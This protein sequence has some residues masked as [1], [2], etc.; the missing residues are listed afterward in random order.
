MLDLR[1]E[2]NDLLLQA[3]ALAL[4][5]SFCSGNAVDAVVSEY[6][7]PIENYL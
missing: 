6:F 7:G 3:N 4:R 5:P 2:G 1:A